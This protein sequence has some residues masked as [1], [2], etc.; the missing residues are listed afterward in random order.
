MAQLRW[1]AGARRRSHKTTMRAV[2]TASRPSRPTATAGPHTTRATRRT[3]LR[4]TG[5]AR[6]AVCVVNKVSGARHLLLT[7]VVL[8]ARVRARAA[9]MGSTCVPPLLWQ[10]PPPRTHSLPPYCS[11]TDVSPSDDASSS[12]SEPSASSSWRSCSSSVRSASFMLSSWEA[13]LARATRASTSARLGGRA[14]GGGAMSS[15]FT[16]PSISLN[17]LGSSSAITWWSNDSSGVPAS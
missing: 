2:T 16:V 7:G 8:L 5:D 9:S 4:R 15:S 3:T 14:P 11:D 10:P 17:S 13:S 6:V 12:E 1:P